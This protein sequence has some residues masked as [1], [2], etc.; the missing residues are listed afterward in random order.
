MGEG[1]GLGEGIR[2]SSRD[3]NRRGNNLAQQWFPI[4]YRPGIFPHHS[5]FEQIYN[6]KHQEL[7]HKPLK[8]VFQQKDDNSEYEKNKI[9]NCTTLTFFIRPLRV[10][11]KTTVLLR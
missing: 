6:T 1:V 2:K 3:F 5:N 4:S 11:A 10:P 8:T 7:H 9:Y